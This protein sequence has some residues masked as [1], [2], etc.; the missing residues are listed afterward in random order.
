MHREMRSCGFAPLERKGYSFPISQKR[1]RNNPLTGFTLLETM[2]YIGLFAVLISG[3][4]IASMPIITG[5]QRMNDRIMI[6]NEVALVTKTIPSLV[7]Q[8]RVVTA[9]SAGSS[10]GTLTL[11]TYSDGGPEITY[12]FYA[13]GGAIMARV[14]P[15][16]VPVSSVPL[17]ASRVRFESFLVRHIPGTVTTPA[18]IEF[19]FEANGLAYGPYRSYLSL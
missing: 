4:I 8:A 3:V 11:T 15:T 13:E 19:T 9:P 17:T 6:E 7:P 18:A 2:I 10:G 12:T 16:G 1:I 5:A 14:G